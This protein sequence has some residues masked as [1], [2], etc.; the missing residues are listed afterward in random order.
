MFLGVGAPLPRDGVAGVD[1]D[2]RR[3]ERLAVGTNDDRRVGGK[4]RARDQQSSG[5]EQRRTARVFPCDDPARPPGSPQSRAG[6]A[7]R[8]VRS[9]GCRPEE[10]PYQLVAPFCGRAGLQRRR[11]LSASTRP[12]PRRPGGR[13][14][15]DG[16]RRRPHR[17]WGSA[18]PRRPSSSSRSSPTPSS[19]HDGS[20]V[21]RRS[22]RAPAACTAASCTTARPCSAST[23]PSTR[24]AAW[25]SP[26]AST[27]QL[28][29]P[30]GEQHGRRH[31]HARARRH[32]PA[33]RAHRP[34]PPRARR[35][36][37]GMS[38]YLG[39]LAGAA[40]SH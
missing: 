1:R 10:R 11:A 16:D 32:P 38:G 26:G 17:G 25:S 34:P 22:T 27:A 37:R 36:R 24:R 30:P 39:Q 7:S 13:G 8:N 4:R 14:P 29:V 6:A 40:E 12:R 31:A 18:S 21:R 35:T 28:A 33:A 2:V 15:E 5:Q 20:G 19:T 23:S 9:V 3:N